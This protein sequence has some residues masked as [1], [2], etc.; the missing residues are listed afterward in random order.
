MKLDEATLRI[1]TIAQYLVNRSLH[2]FHYIFLNLA[3]YSTAFLFLKQK[4]V[5]KTKL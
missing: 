5:S 1:K 3:L 2:T 4:L